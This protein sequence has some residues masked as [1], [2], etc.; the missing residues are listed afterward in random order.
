MQ[1]EENKVVSRVLSFMGLMRGRISL[2]WRG[3]GHR[4]IW[5]SG[6]HYYA[7]LTDYPLYLLVL[8]IL[9]MEMRALPVVRSNALMI[10]T[11]V[12]L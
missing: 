2:W 12:I 9:R 7:T 11:M 5:V 1:T 8:L 4:Q 10:K 3:I 6:S